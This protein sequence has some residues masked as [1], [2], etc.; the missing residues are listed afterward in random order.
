MRLGYKLAAEAFGPKELIRQAV[1]A[2]ECGF[3]FVE[4]SDHFHPWLEVQG[5][6]P[7]AWSVLGAIAARTTRLGL[8]TGV[9]CPTVRYHPA[10]IAQAAAT[11][12]IISDDR[13]TLGVGSGERLNEHVVGGCFPGVRERHALLVEALEIIEL[14]WRGG[15]R[16]YD[17]TYL[18]LEDAQV[19][20]LPEKLPAIAVAAGGKDAARLAAMHG[21]GLFATEPRADLVETFTAAG[22]S[23]PKY[24]E[25]SVAWAPDEEA[26]VRAAHETSRWS[27]LGWKVMSELPNPVNFEAASATVRP[28]D[29]REQMVTGPDPQRYRDA[30]AAYEKAG[31]DHVALMNAGPDPDGFLAFCERELIGQPRG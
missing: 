4:I 27:V 10:I 31:Y 19:F 22:G 23:G 5:H 18:S 28:D 3:D 21:G 8:A 24:A 26:A 25:L 29:V 14:L 17:G 12:A 20:D 15:Y 1:R 9:T 2:E 16:S 11:L 7:F 30:I 13:F 6:S